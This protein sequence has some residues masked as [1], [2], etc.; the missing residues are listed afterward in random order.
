MTRGA[1]SI[2]VVVDP[3]A[4]VVPNSIWVD[5]ASSVVKVMV[6]VVFVVDEATLEIVGAVTS[7][8]VVVTVKFPDV[9]VL[10]DPSVEITRKLYVVQEVIP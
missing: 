5:A 10:P 1:V 9:W 4:S 2:S 7:Q 6:A 8:P 3:Y